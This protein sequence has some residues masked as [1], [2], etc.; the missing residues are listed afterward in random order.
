MTMA[1]G[2]DLMMTIDAQ[3]STRCDEKRRAVAVS[4]ATLS[5]RE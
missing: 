2:V 5:L 3:Q 4:T 1:R